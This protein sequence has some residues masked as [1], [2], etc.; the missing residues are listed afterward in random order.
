MSCSKKNEKL[1]IKKKKVKVLFFTFSGAILLFV[2]KKLF[3]YLFSRI[4]SIEFWKNQRAKPK[5]REFDDVTNTIG[6]QMIVG[7]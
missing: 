3:F 4:R 1:Q 6:E 7:K 5:E 2:H